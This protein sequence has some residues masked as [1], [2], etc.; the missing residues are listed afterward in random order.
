[1]IAMRM[2]TWRRRPN[3]IAP[4]RQYGFDEMLHDIL[5]FAFSMLVDGGRLCMWLPIANEADVPL[6]LPRHPGLEL[7]SVCIQDFNKCKAA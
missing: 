4:K 5:E 2:L 1:M 6:D 7:S 3:Y